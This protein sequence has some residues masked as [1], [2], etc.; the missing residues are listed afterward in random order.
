MIINRNEKCSASIAL[1]AI[2]TVI[3]CLY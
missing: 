2:T 3:Y 1:S